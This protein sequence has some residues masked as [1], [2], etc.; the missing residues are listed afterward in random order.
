M[1]RGVAVLQVL[2]ARKGR[3][4]PEA[5][6]VARGQGLGQRQHARVF[7]NNEATAARHHTGQ[8]VLKRCKLVERH[9]A[10]RQP[11]KGSAHDQ[12]GSK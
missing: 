9:V 8:G 2:E 6:A 11:Q 12:A 7:L 1:M 10:Q 4:T 3:L 5:R